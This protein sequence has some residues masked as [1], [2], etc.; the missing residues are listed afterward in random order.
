MIG[1]QNHSVN[2]RI[3]ITIFAPKINVYANFVYIFSK[4]L[5]FR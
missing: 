5:R 3:W 4:I 2:Y 1:I